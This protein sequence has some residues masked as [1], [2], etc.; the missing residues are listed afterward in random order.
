MAMSTSL[1]LLLLQR[2]ELGMDMDPDT[3]SAPHQLLTDLILGHFNR[4]QQLE[5]NLKVPYYTNLLLF[6]S[7]EMAVT[8]RRFF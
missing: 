2:N 4:T 1:F 8:S 7:F 5:D 3:H 6:G